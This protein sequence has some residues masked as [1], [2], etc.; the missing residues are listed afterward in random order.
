MP[1]DVSYVAYIIRALIIFMF[2]VTA[3][4]NNTN[5]HLISD[6]LH[7]IYLAVKYFL[8]L[9]CKW[10]MH[11]IYIK[12]LHHVF[13]VRHNWRLI[14]NISWHYLSW[15]LSMSIYYLLLEVV[16]QFN[17]LLEFFAV[18]LNVLYLR[19]LNI[20]LVETQIFDATNQWLLPF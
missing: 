3:R 9:Y 20:S 2:Q 13:M 18:F 17:Y 6:N 5:R 16:S 12:M 19:F 11:T 8:Y 10:L 14:S 15:M 1:N 7:Y 4:Q